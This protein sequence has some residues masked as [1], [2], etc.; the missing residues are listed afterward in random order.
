MFPSLQKL[1]AFNGGI[2][3]DDA[4][5]STAY[6]NDG[7][8]AAEEGNLYGNVVGFQQQRRHQSSDW[9]Q[10]RAIVG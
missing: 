8:E 2:S 1:E 9:E 5:E 4:F 3:G 7:A 10:F 6:G